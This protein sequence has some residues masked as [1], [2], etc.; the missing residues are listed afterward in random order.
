MREV[1]LDEIGSWSEVKIE[2]IRKYASAYTQILSKK[3]AI[4][5]F[6]YIDGFAGAGKHLSKSTGEEIPG[7]PQ[8]ALKISPPFHEYHFVDLNKDKTDLLETL[9]KERENVFVYQKN[10]NEVLPNQIFP[11]ARYE[12]FHRALCILDPYGLHLNWEVIYRAGQLRSM[13]IFINFPIMD[14]NM[15]V[16][17]DKISRVSESD[18]ARMSSFWGDESWIDVGYHSGQQDLFGG[19]SYLPREKKHLVNAFQERLKTVAGFSYVPDPMPMRNSSNAIVYWLFFASQQSVASHIIT[20][21][22][23]K[24]QAPGKD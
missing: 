1:R 10:C 20:D 24:Y 16:L 23:R 6:I 11:R 19:D 13:D 9:K 21:I 14:I 2:I 15:N 18:K 5:K 12:D 4:K 7:T 22:F 8:E 3:P 17:K